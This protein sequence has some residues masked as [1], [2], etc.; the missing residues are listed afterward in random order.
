[1]FYNLT[2]T[3]E[4]GLTTLADN[5]LISGEDATMGCPVYDRDDGDDGLEPVHLVL[6]EHLARRR[7]A[8]NCGAMPGDIGW[9]IWHGEVPVARWCDVCLSRPVPKLSDDLN[10]TQLDGRACI[11]CGA[12]HQ[13]LRPVEAWSERSAQL[14]ECA[15]GE[16]C[17]RRRRD[18]STGG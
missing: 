17:D 2:G 8:A 1:L 12:A 16:S 10:E 13:P 3:R 18:T 11:R 5:E 15:D 14:F 4:A 6:D 9:L 7:A